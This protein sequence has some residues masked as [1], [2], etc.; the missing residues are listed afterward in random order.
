MNYPAASGRGIKN[1]RT[2]VVALDG[3]GYN[4]LA[5]LFLNILVDDGFVACSTHGTDIIAVCP[6]FSSPKS[7]FY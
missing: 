6:K 1:H 5:S 2:T 3:V 4:L 7:F